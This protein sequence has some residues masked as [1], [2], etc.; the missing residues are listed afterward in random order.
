M[1]SDLLNSEYIN[2]EEFEEVILVH[3]KFLNNNLMDNLRK[4]LKQKYPV[5]FKNRG[6]VFDVKKIQILENLITPLGQSKFRV[7]FQT[8]LYKPEV[9]HVFRSKLCKSQV[10]D[11]YWTEIS[12]LVIFLN[13]D[14]NYA[15]NDYVTVQITNVKADNILCFGTII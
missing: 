5:C 8:D 12:P 11:K 14:H 10:G 6:F 15:E 4:I 1:N 7:K 13:N 2:E 3:P 9:G